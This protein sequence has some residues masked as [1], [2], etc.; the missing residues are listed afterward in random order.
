MKAFWVVCF[1]RSGELPLA[2]VKDQAQTDIFDIVLGKKSRNGKVDLWFHLLLHFFS[3]QLPD[4]LLEDL[5]VHIEPHRSDVPGLSI[6]QEGSG[7]PNL[8]VMEGQL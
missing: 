2:P 5:E 1:I 4:C 7:T 3:L 8:Q 6:A